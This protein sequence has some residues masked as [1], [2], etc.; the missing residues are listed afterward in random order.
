ML[1]LDNLTDMILAIVAIL[2]NG[3]IIK[4]IAVDTTY[5]MIPDI[6]ENNKITLIFLLLFYILCCTEFV[7]FICICLA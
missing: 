4:N 6:K 5:R 3:I 1:A 2:I 7:A